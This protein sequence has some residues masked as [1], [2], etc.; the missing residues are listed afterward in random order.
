MSLSPITFQRSGSRYGDVSA[1]NFIILIIVLNLK[2]QNDPIFHEKDERKVQKLKPA[3]VQ[4]SFTLFWCYFLRF[5]SFAVL[6]RSSSPLLSAGSLSSSGVESLWWSSSVVKSSLLMFPAGIRPTLG[7]DADTSRLSS[8]RRLALDD[9]TARISLS[10][11]YISPPW[12][13]TV[14]NNVSQ[15]NSSANV[16]P[17]N[18]FASERYKNLYFNVKSVLAAAWG[19]SVE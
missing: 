9:L 7:G 11:F 13:V 3:V 5:L 12:E 16:G 10:S 4:D 14:S 17:S 6:L 8:Q 19:K 1:V 18:Q 15:Q 2:R